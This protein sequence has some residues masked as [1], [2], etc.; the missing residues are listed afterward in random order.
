MKFDRF[1]GEQELL[2]FRLTDGYGLVTT[3]R[4]ILERE[5]HNPRLNIKERQPPE[6]YPLCNFEKAEIKS[7]TIVVNFKGWK[8]ALICLPMY[9]PSLFQ[10]IKDYIEEA[11]KNWR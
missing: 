5:K 2:S 4:L 11:A 3:H 9:S 8:T 7:D 1:S 6:M 10:E